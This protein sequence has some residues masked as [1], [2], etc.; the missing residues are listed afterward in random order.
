[1]GGGRT[2]FGI[3]M[4]APNRRRRSK[5]QKGR[6]LRRYSNRRLTAVGG[7]SLRFGG[8]HTALHRPA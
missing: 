6:K 8:T 3:E 4:I 1:M 7:W 2:A 5:T